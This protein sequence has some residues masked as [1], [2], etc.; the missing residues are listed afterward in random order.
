MIV[1]DD[2]EGAMWCFDLFMSFCFIA[3]LVISFHTALWV[4][5]AW[6]TSKSA[7]ARSYMRGWFWIDAPSS[8]PLEVL[9]GRSIHA[10]RGPARARVAPA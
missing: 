4:D 6:V 5:G 7:I 3:D 9:A 2:A 8:L 10:L 1:D